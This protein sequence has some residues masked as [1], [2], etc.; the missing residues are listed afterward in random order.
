MALYNNLTD[1]MTDIA[2]AIR[3][4]EGGG[5]AAPRIRPNDFASR[6][7][8]LN[9]TKSNEGVL[10]VGDILHLF[11]SNEVG[12]YFFYCLN[13]DENSSLSLTMGDIEK[14]MNMQFDN[15]ENSYNL[16]VSYNGDGTCRF[17]CSPYPASDEYVLPSTYGLLE[18][19]K[20]DVDLFF[21]A[22][23][24]QELYMYYV[25]LPWYIAS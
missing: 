17:S 21:N 9:T 13:G 18:G 25:C 3:E 8:G 19:D 7:R 16:I 23:P 6:I 24:T 5:G 10:P 14:S 4:V 2:T 22:S 1:C 11:N 15:A 12:T 20:G